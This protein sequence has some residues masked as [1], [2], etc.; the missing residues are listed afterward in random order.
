MSGYQ[1]LLVLLFAVM[2]DFRSLR[3]ILMSVNTDARY[4]AHAGGH[5]SLS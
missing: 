3:D 1:H 2:K 5:P 4:L